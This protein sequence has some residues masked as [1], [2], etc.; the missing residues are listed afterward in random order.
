MLFGLWLFYP[1]F[2]AYF[3]INIDEGVRLTRLEWM[4]MALIVS[5]FGTFEIFS[6]RMSRELS[7]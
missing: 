5:I 2:W 4:G 3:G 6:N 7:V 1:E